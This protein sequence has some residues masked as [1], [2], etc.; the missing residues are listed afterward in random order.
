MKHK[1]SAAAR[2][3]AEKKVTPSRRI[4]VPKGHKAVVYLPGEGLPEEDVL[5]MVSTGSLFTQVLRKDTMLIIAV[6]G[7]S[8]PYHNLIEMGCL[9]ASWG[10]DKNVNKRS[11]SP[12]ET[13]STIM[14]YLGSYDID[15]ANLII[16]DVLSSHAKRISAEL[17]DRIAFR[18]GAIRDMENTL[19][20]TESDLTRAQKGM[21]TF[22][23][24]A[25]SF[26]SIS[27]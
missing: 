20:A 19:K 7:K 8:I 11:P 26:G 16:Q 2:K 14:A 22:R 4:T 24:I 9:P 27:R 15:T 25:G 13:I 21:E 17:T 3:V 12:D 5:S 10:G 1:A 18:E 6:A 23:N